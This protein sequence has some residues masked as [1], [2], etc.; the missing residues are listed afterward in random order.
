MSDKITWLN[1]GHEFWDQTLLKDL[2]EGYSGDRS[3]TVIPGAITNELHFDTDIVIVTSDE[4]SKYPTDNLTNGVYVTYPNR[5]KHWN[6]DGYLPIGYRPETRERVKNYGISSKSLDWFFA[7]QNTHQSRRDCI[8]QLENLPNGKL[9]VTNAFADGIGYTE[10]MAYMCRA[11]V[12]PCP[13]GPVSPDSFR[14]Y[15]AL[16]AGCIPIPENKAFWT[17]L[18]GEVPFPVV[19]DWDQLPSMIKHFKDRPDVSNKCFAW[20]QLKKKELKWKLR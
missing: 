4:E 7:G 5:D 8:Q 3:I 11:K 16:E 13:G 1:Q 10:Y 15:E 6:V 12:V 18:F 9:V 17:M 19:D 2:L 14:L 20:W